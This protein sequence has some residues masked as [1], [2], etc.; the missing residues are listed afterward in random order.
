METC[1]A[2]STSFVQFGPGHARASHYDLDL[3]VDFEHSKLVGSVSVTCEGAGCLILDTRDLKIGGVFLKN[4]NGSRTPL[5]FLVDISQKDPTMGVPVVVTLGD[6]AHSVVIVEYETSPNSSALQWLTP[7]QTT[8]KKFPFLFSQCQAIHAR[9]MLPCQDVCQVKATYTAKVA[10]PK[11]LTVLMSA[12]QLAANS[13][14]STFEFSQ[15]VP[16]PPY[17]IAIVCGELETRAL[18]ARSA[19]WAEPAVVEK[20]AAEFEDT[21]QL[22]AIAEDLC[23]PYRFGRF[24]LLVLPPSFPYGGMEN[25]CLTF[26]TPTLLA[27]DKSQVAVIAH[28][29]A[30]SWSGNLATNASW[31]DFWLNEGLTVFTEKKIVQRMFGSDAA[32]IRGQD[33]WDHLAQYVAEVG[34][35]HEYTKLCP[36]INRGR[37]RMIHSVWFRTKKGLLCFGV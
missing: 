24:D 13:N 15:T 12:Q 3:V 31:E 2:D 4:L 17:L 9:S 26:V 32:H 23:G 6:V 19:V 5:P 22:I 36:R 21:E 35:E 28:E 27:G 20:A 8:S 16:I 30:H 11:G 25:P 10:C 7:E 14:T 34:P 37:T 1:F 33:G 29:L 18:G